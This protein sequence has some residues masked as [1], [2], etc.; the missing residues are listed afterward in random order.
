[1]AIGLIFAAELA[2]ELGRIDAARV[3]EHRAVVAGE[4]DLMTRPPERLDVDELVALM[5]RDKKALNGLTF[6]LDGPD[7]VE[8][9][10][11]RRRSAPSAP[12]SNGSSTSW[13]QTP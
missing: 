2:H 4:Y 5:H 8:V 6:V 10:D 11:R 1:M 13:C 7:G 9:V 3:D 12:P